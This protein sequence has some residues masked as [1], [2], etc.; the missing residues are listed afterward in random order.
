[1]ATI[2]A[3]AVKP[4]FEGTTPICPLVCGLGGVL[5]VCGMWLGENLLLV[6]EVLVMPTDIDPPPPVPPLLLTLV[7]P[8]SLVVLQQAHASL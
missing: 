2:A 3:A 5:A 4:M 1:M 8:G 6:L 7:I